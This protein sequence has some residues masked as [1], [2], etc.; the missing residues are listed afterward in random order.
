MAAGRGCGST[1]LA[2]GRLGPGR[3][4]RRCPITSR[5]TGTAWSMA[6]PEGEH[7]EPPIQLWV[8][9]A[10]CSA[11]RHLTAWTRFRGPGLTCDHRS[12]TGLAAGDDLRAD[13]RTPANGQRV[14]AFAKW[15]H[16]D[17]VAFRLPLLRDS[18]S[19]LGNTDR[20]FPRCHPP[21]RSA[22][23]PRRPQ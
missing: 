3:P 8:A 15:G 19:D 21:R 13:A 6:L 17:I 9:E 14:E 11:I 23:G 5:G 22:I 12:T 18:S 1:D 20:N 4:A 10:S 7:A 16:C 2:L